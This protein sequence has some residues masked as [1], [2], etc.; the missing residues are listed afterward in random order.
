MVRYQPHTSTR[1]R[2]GGR[3]KE[4]QQKVGKVMKNSTAAASQGKI[5]TPQVKNQTNLAVRAQREVS[6]GPS[7]H[8][9]R[10]GVM[11]IW[12]SGSHGDLSNLHT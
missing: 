8:Q 10:K 6:E 12:G 11:G 2:M 1:K 4:T 9:R 3:P 5:N 7:G